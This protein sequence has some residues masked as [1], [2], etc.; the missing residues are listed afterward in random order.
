[1]PWALFHLLLTF[2]LSLPRLDLV[3][4]RESD[5]SAWPESG[6]PRSA[7]QVAIK[8][9]SLSPNKNNEKQCHDRLDIDEIAA[10]TICMRR[11]PALHLKW[12]KG[13]RVGVRL[14]FL[15][16]KGHGLSTFHSGHTRATRLNIAWPLTI[17]S[18]HTWRDQS[19]LYKIPLSN[20]T[21]SHT[22]L[23]DQKGRLKRGMR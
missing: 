19:L 17:S 7:A 4:C 23:Q 1:M 12:K 16:L 13:G 5:T 6:R 2:P 22:T 9:D 18:S 8:N 3:S 20:T 15:T 10:V 14:S 21:H 11:L